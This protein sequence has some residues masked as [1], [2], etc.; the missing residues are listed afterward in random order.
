[1]HAR[2]FQSRVYEYYQPEVGSVARP[3]ELDV[4]KR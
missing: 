2:T 3:V 4:R 1:M